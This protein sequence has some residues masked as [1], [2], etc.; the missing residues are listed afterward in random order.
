MY[1]QE[2]YIYFKG[3]ED[4][5]KAMGNPIKMGTSEM[6][7]L[8]TKDKRCYTC[9]GEMHGKEQCPVLNKHIEDREHK[10]RLMNFHS[11]AVGG[12]RKGMTYADLV[13]GKGNN[14]QG[15]KKREQR[16]RQRRKGPRD[17]ETR[18]HGYGGEDTRRSHSTKK[19]ATIETNGLHEGDCR[20]DGEAESLGGNYR[21]HATNND[22]DD[23]E[24]NAVDDREPNAV[25]GG[26]TRHGQGTAG[27][28]NE[29]DW[30]RK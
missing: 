5:A 27:H 13:E 3:T 16:G 24:P 28:D 8:H 30:E 22:P 25:D 10:R 20:Y 23:R 15:Q 17:C 14:K 12:V 6:V 1:R 21:G 4:M 29:C 18:D 9:N 7:Y 11:K 26:D 2:A 19:G